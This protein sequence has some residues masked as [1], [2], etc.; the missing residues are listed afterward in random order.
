VFWDRNAV[1]EAVPWFRDVSRNAYLR[2][3]VS[4][5]GVVNVVLGLLELGAVWSR[6]TRPTGAAAAPPEA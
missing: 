1:L 3:A 4:G 5:L 2:G 6:W